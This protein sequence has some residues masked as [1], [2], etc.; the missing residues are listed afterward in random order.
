MVCFSGRGP[1]T[2]ASLTPRGDC[3]Q[4]KVKGAHTL[5]QA[6]AIRAKELENVE[7]AITL[8]YVAPSKETFSEITKRYLA[9]QKVRLTPRS[10]EGGIETVSERTYC[11]RFLRR[12]VLEDGVSEGNRS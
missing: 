12:V 5:T 8:G 1:F 9:H 2:L 11:A 4:R 3:R 10:A 7:R 6:L